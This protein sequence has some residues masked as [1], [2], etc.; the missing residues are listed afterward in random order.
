M[1]YVFLAL[2]IVVFASLARGEEKGAP[3][4]AKGDKATDASEKKDAAQPHEGV[5]RAI[6]AVLGGARLSDTEVN[7]INL[8]VKGDN[9]EVIIGGER[10]D[11]GTCKVDATT[12]P[13][14]LTIKGTEGP[15][16][17]KTIL[18]IF[19][20]KDADSLR[21]CYDLSGKEFPKEFKAPRESLLFLVGYRRQKEQPTDKPVAK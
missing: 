19:E 6:A 12:T 9:Y 21:V 17:G 15:N 7:A 11:K 1:R 4:K 5:W 13:K 16:Q 14:R 8:K 10:P 18:A 3:D 2:M 20:M